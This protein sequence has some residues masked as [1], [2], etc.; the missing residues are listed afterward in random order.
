MGGVFLIK[1]VYTVCSE[2]QENVGFHIG[3][4]LN[5]YSYSVELLHVT[6]TKL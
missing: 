1:C 5:M 6:H 4:V 2:V 3:L